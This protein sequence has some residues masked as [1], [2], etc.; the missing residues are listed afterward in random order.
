MKD[1]ESKSSPATELTTA[2]ESPA[3]ELARAAELTTAAEST[4]KPESA[5][6]EVSPDQDDSSVEKRNP[7]SVKIKSKR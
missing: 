3:L 1:F 5:A 2:V 7:R 4:E 6:T